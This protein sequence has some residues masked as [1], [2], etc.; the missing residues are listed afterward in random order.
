M[1]D[2][3][4]V[5]DRDP[6]RDRGP[7]RRLFR[8]G[9]RRPAAREATDWEITH[10]LAEVADRLENEGW[11]PEDA[12][13]EARRRFGRTRAYRRRI[14]RIAR[15][16]M[17]MMVWTNLRVATREMVVTSVRSLARQ[18]GLTL[19]VALT[20][21]LG[22]GANA[23]MFRILDR[24]LFQP[25][26]YVVDHDQV[27]RVVVERT[28]LGQLSR[29][30]IG[31]YPDVVDLRAHGGLDAVAAYAPREMTLGSGEGAEKV[32]A[33]I[34]EHTLF[35]LLGVTAERGRFFG[36]ADDQPGAEPVAIVSHEFWA[37]ATGADPDILGSTLELD[38]TP[39]TVIGV[40]PPGFT[41]AD[42]AP[43]D[44]WL[45]LQTGG[46]LT[47]EN[48][49]WR[50]SRGYYWLSAVARLGDGVGVEAAAAEA[51][52]L[53]RAGRREELEAGRYDPEVRIALDPLILARGPEAGAES[54]VARWLGGVT[55]LLLVIV[56]A[57]VA[58]LLLARGTRRHR[59]VAVRLALGVS[60]RRL[61]G[62]TL[63]ETALLGLL[64]S[65]VGLAVAYWG[66]T[67][68]RSL[69]LPDVQFTGALGLRVVA[70]TV[71]LSLLAG[72]V[73]GVA[74]ALQASRLELARDLAQGARGTRGR[75]RTRDL[76]TAG[77]AALSVLLL[78]G[79]GLFLRSVGQVR[80][81]DLGLD[82]DRLVTAGLEFEESAAFAGLET[83]SPLASDGAA[84]LDTADRNRIYRAAMERLAAVPGVES[85]AAT[86]SPFGW[87]FAGPISVPGW[88]SLPGL[89]GGGPYYHNVTPGYFAT[90]GQRILQGRALEPSD[91]AG[92][93]PVTVISETMARTLWPDGDAL[94]GCL[95]L[96]EG[97]GASETS[98]VCT[99]VVGVVE[100]ASRGQLEEDA[101][102]AYY[103]P[104]A[105]REGRAI[106]GLYVR[107]A[108]PDRALPSIA[109]A[110]R[111]SDPKVR[112][113]KVA[114]LRDVLEPQARSWTLGAA[115]FT[116][117]GALALLVAGIG[118]YGV[119][120][121]HVAERT[122]ELGIR[123][124]L[125]AAKGRLLRGVLSDGVRLTVV[126][127]VAG[128]GLAL[129]MGR[130]AEP[131]F[132]RVSPRDPAVL[133][134]V[135]VTLIAVGL[136]ASL[137]PGLR[138]TRVDPMDALRIE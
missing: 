16:R 57:N 65:A 2:R 111:T 13:T 8:L 48:D 5:R 67:A 99:T 61:V 125:G 39:F 104:M 74:P 115:L 54:Q 20:L 76:L 73:A 83:P 40:A 79:A 63:M 41:G 129:F 10:H 59:E 117:F 31:T 89:P 43:V 25:P 84:S 28:F 52:A 53:H 45:P 9:L 29:G 6:V 66:G 81:L 32:R 87:G 62:G 131:L 12:V 97:P 94:G 119:L 118:L 138:A 60:R 55:L 98:D 127:V 15:R 24:L 50:E 36:A 135:A 68:I 101:H 26:A 88:D 91:D 14:E 1:G 100:D 23:S 82:V 78:V 21:G 116:V 80:S 75:S 126:G 92:G 120:A 72:S 90:V 44:T 17:M 102:M 112:F 33:V 46:V 77:Q 64:G 30:G 51:T 11:D 86:T 105:Q 38:G 47:W 103:L 85:V 58:N 128:I 132:F 107:A 35:S 4:P 22:I 27:K 49:S 106:N 137:L 56:C 122:R 7:V 70:F 134:G 19:I 109:T 113:A 123:A 114:T 34:A 69:L 121:F 96:P 42:V 93:A 110:L 95:H 71:G 37:R 124:A 130:F 18:P 133:I 136:L 108:D 3:G